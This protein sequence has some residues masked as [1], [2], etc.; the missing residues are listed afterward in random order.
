MSGLRT[1][2]AIAAHD[3]AREFRRPVAISSVLLFGVASLVVLRLALGGGAKPDDGI[4]AGALWIVLVF[5]ALLGTAR[6]WASER[7]DG[8]LDALLMAPASR[9]T[10]HLGKVIAAAATTVVLHAVLLVLYLGLFGAPPGSGVVLLVAT[11]LLADVG[12]AVVGVL[13]A[14]LGMRA[15]S[16]DLLGP[17]M[18]LPL[19]IPLV[20]AAVTASLSAW[21]LSNDS[22]TQL[23]IFLVAYDATFLLAGVAAFP[24][25]AVE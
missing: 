3:L 17:T 7:E 16:R 5:A 6:A 23:L 22:V 24:E 19:V 9:S 18:F 14:G 4:L 11:V 2:F 13:V 10:V 8:V 20:I 15:R 21:D 25:L 1:A 12:F